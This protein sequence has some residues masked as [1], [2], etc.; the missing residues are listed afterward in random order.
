VSQLQQLL[1]A[2]FY[3]EMTKEDFKKLRSYRSADPKD[4]KDNSEE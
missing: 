1:F 4:N 2:P 3:K